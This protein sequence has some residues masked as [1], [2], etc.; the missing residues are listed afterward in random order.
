M[1]L[2]TSGSFR[3]YSYTPS[4]LSGVRGDPLIAAYWADVDL[5]RAGAV[6]YRETNSATDLSMATVHIQAA[7]FS[8]YQ[9][10][11]AVIVTYDGVGYY[12]CHSDKVGFMICLNKLSI[13]TK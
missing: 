4:S 1:T 13:C 10:S 6:Y 8:G 2:P 5:R 7:G 12:N 11:S 9:P 3:S